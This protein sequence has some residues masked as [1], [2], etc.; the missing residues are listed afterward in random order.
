MK[1]YPLFSVRIN[2]NDALNNIARVFDSG[3]IN[4]GSQVLELEKKLKQF[5]DVQNLTL[6][7]S[8]TSAITLALRILGISQGDE[9]ISTAMTCVATNTPIFN[10]GAKIVWADI[11][12]STGM[13]SPKDAESKIT[14]RTKAIVV[15][16]WAGNPCNLE[17][18][19][20]LSRKYSIPIIQDA[21]HAFGAKYLGKSIADFTDF[22]CF[23]FQAIK[24]FTT[25]DGGALICKNPKDHTLARK[26]KWF[27]YDRDNV[28]DEKGEW[29]GQKWAA[30]ISKNEVGY[31]FNMN[32]LSAAIGL[33]NLD[34]ID[35]TLKTHR[36]NASVYKSLL[37][38][39]PRI[40]LLEELK[41]SE[42]SYWV[43]T[44]KLKTRKDIRD[45]ILE[46]LNLLGIQAGLVHLPNNSYS[47]FK[48]FSIPIPNTENFSNTQISLPCGWWLNKADCE[49]I[50]I[51]LLKLTLEY[52]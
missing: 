30:D 40:E 50:A 47:A 28:K 14:H 42:S 38:S 4:E 39:S 51:S 5:L 10:S 29:R 2:K 46:E 43:Y 6:V 21:A 36:E 22:T 23:S 3:Y 33:S 24:H 32:N 1:Q 27:G 18:F 25:G 44:L 20:N 26:L 45:K 37:A 34:K 12:L 48:K 9:V 41:N 49:F 16:D 8:G 13:I 35:E 52:I 19:A 31:K 7:N 17:A 11:D 15:V